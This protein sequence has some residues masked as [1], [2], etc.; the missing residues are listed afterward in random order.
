MNIGEKSELKKLEKY[1]AKYLIAK[2]KKQCLVTASFMLS[3]GETRK[4]DEAIRI[5][6]VLEGGKNGHINKSK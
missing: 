4:A 5:Y 6:K 1:K 3:Q 2:I